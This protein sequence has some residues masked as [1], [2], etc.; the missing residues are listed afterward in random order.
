MAD[1]NTA[2]S[3]YPEYK[4]ILWNTSIYPYL[5]VSDWQN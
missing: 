1:K 4:G 3:R 5:D 2:D